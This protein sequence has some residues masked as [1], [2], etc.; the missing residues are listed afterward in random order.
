MVNALL[1]ESD[2]PIIKAPCWNWFL[3]LVQFKIISWLFGSLHCFKIFHWVNLSF[4]FFWRFLQ[5]KGLI[6]TK[7]RSQIP[8]GCG[9]VLGLEAPL[10]MRESW[11]ERNKA[12]KH[13]FTMHFSDYFRTKTLMN[14]FGLN[15]HLKT[16]FFNFS[17][18]CNFFEC[19]TNTHSNTLLSFFFIWWKFLKASFLDNLV[20]K[21][22]ITN[23]FPPNFL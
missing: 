1:T 7:K 18:N 13:K 12:W 14:N 19:F 22:R 15:L 23:I 4:S 16:S 20:E 9:W 2:F 6:Q 3:K 10:T 8:G 5:V 11:M 17:W 21:H